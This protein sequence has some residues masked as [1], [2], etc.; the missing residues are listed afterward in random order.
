MFACLQPCRKIHCDELV[1]RAMNLA[2]NCCASLVIRRATPDVTGQLQ[3]R[4]LL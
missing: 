2:T 3:H 4:P 1:V